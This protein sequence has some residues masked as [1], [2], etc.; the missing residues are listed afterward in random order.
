[1]HGVAYSPGTSFNGAFSSATQFPEAITI[2]AAFD[3]GAIELV[4]TI[5]GVEARAFGNNNHSGLDFWTPN[6]N[7]YKDPR[8]GRGHETP[9][10]DPLVSSRYVKAFVTGM[11]GNASTHRV[12]PTCK[13]FAG[14]DLEAS[15]YSFDAQ[16]SLQDLAKYYLPPFQACTRDAKVASVMCSYNSVNGEP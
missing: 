6:I 10:E 16:I 5:V 4:G 12:L 14:Y 15:R 9:G 2:A 1:L 8:W 7:P 11:Q 13:H 3:D